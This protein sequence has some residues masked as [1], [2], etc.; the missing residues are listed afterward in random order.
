MRSIVALILL[1]AG[2]AAQERQMTPQLYIAA[3][4]SRGSQWDTVKA[5]IAQPHFADHGRNL[6]RLQREGKIALGARFGEFGL[7][8]FKTGNEQEVRAM[9][10]EDSLVVK[11]ILTMKL[12][13]FNPFYKGCI[14]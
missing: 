14:E 13:P 8:V 2:A 1:T 5:P 10:A 11:D 3:Q 4:F 7:V 9:F 12:M 6:Q